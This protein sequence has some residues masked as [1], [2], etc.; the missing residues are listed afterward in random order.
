MLLR[1]GQGQFWVVTTFGIIRLLKK[2][3][4]I[5]Y[6]CFKSL[7][8]IFIFLMDLFRRKQHLAFCSRHEMSF[9]EQKRDCARSHFSVCGCY[10][11]ESWAFTYPFRISLI[12]T[13]NYWSYFGHFSNSR[14][15]W[16][17]TIHANQRQGRLKAKKIRVLFGKEVI[18]LLQT[19]ILKRKSF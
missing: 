11:N 18:N 10:A 1:S 5:F 6:V 3:S 14:H 19:Q 13:L 12:L 7:K 4:P 16:A 8:V 15:I 9:N 17:N 2:V